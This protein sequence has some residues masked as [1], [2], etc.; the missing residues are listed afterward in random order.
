MRGY[1]RYELGDD[2]AA[3]LVPAYEQSR[4]GISAEGLMVAALTDR[5]RR[6]P[7]IRIAE[8]LHRARSSPVYMYN[9]AY[10]GSDPTAYAI[11]GCD[12]PYTFDTPAIDR[13]DDLEAGH[14]ADQFCDA[15]L[16]FAR[17]GDPNHAG[18]P[19]WQPYDPELRATMVFEAEARSLNDPWS[20]E[21][22]A[23]DAVPVTGD[24]T[25]PIDNGAERRVT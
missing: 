18:L 6:I 21:R 10:G 3:H 7:A 1:L 4:P 8:A 19:T 13:P 17:T 15:W 24:P 22:T 25:R 9:F 23:W 14:V 11:H 20:A 12:I 2:L 5:D 16:A